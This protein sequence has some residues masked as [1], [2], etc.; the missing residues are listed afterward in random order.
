MVSSKAPFGDFESVHQNVEDEQSLELL[1]PCLWLCRS[2]VG[3]GRGTA[4]PPS[5][6]LRVALRT[7]SSSAPLE[8]EFKNAVLTTLSVLAAT[9]L[10]VALAGISSL[11][12]CL[13]Q[14]CGYCKTR[15]WV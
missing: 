4:G 3:G 12:P 1:T 5:P 11:P 14:L 8:L 6:G 7:F 2:A 15:L 10:L 9:S 13:G